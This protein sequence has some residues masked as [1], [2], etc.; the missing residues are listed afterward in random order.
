MAKDVTLPAVSWVAIHHKSQHGGRMCRGLSNM[1]SN[2]LGGR[3]LRSCKLTP[4]KPRA[5]PLFFLLISLLRISGVRGMDWQGTGRAN[6]RAKAKMSYHWLS[7]MAACRCHRADQVPWNSRKK[8][9]KLPVNLTWVQVAPT[10]TSMTSP[11][12][13]QQSSQCKISIGLPATNTG[14]VQDWQKSKWLTL[15]CGG[16]SKRSTSSGPSEARRCA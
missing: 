4:S 2:A 3:C 10:G 13:N 5:V 6:W 14:W 15:G 1:L 9:S 12:H 16:F 8:S 11:T 7:G